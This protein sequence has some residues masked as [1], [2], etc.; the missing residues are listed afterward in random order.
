MTQLPQTTV[1]SKI[2]DPANNPIPV[3]AY[4]SAISLLLTT[5]QTVHTIILFQELILV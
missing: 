5:P 1:R 2:D 4:S 3:M